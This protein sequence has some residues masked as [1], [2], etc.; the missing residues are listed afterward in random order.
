MGANVWYLSQIKKLFQRNVKL[1][2]RVNNATT[3]CGRSNHFLFSHLGQG[4]GPEK[5]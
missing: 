2:F 1:F 5:Q 4:F 3:H